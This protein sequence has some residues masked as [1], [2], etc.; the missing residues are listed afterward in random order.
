MDP[1]EQWNDQEIWKVAD[2]VRMLTNIL[3]KV[4]HTHTRVVVIAEIIL[5]TC[6]HTRT[7]NLKSKNSNIPEHPVL[8]LDLL[9]SSVFSLHLSGPKDNISVAFVP[10]NVHQ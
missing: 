3:K 1:Y 8:G 10:T 5:H 9:L 7:H 6:A 4:V 2:Q